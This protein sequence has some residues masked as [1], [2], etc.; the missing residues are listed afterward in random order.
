M[1]F[2]RQINL[3]NKLIID[4][5][6][7]SQ[8]MFKRIMLLLLFSHGEDDIDTSRVQVSAQEVNWSLSKLRSLHSN[9]T[10]SKDFVCSSL[11]RFI[12]SVPIYC[13]PGNL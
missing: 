1:D 9:E 12:P 11:S 2:R 8:I 6:I 13:W 7:K 4:E 5:E 10:E 3:N